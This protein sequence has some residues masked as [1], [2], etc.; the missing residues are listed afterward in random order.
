MLVRL[1]IQY[2]LVQDVARDH[3]PEFA[4][5]L[6][7]W[8][9][10]LRC[11]WSCYNLFLGYI[12]KK[13]SVSCYPKT[14]LARHSSFTVSSIAPP[15]LYWLLCPGMFFFCQAKK[16][17]CISSLVLTFLLL[18]SL[19]K[20]SSY[21]DTEYWIWWYVSL[22][23]MSS[24]VSILQLRIFTAKKITTTAK[25]AAFLEHWKRFSNAL[26]ISPTFKS[27]ANPF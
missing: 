2:E 20:T 22:A 27:V 6:M 17:Q 18:R 7:K 12:Y 25:W 4:V 26:K 21:V 11:F 1:F 3:N 24:D 10:E 15:V 19:C 8:F 14:V 5:S 16:M 9:A 23:C 13:V